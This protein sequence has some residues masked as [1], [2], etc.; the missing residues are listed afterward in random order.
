[1]APRLAPACWNSAPPPT[2]LDFGGQAKSLEE[3]LRTSEPI[4]RILEN[5]S[6][7]K[8]PNWYLGAGCIAQTVWNFQH[9]FHLTHGIRDC[10]L[11]YF[12]PSSTS[13]EAEETLSGG[14]RLSLRI[15]P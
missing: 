12:D 6:R 1:M 13:Y 10:D 5:A 7:L 14:D 9:G 11:V 15:S 8:L 4:S 2:D 3:T